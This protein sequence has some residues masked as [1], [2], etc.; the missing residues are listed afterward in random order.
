ELSAASVPFGQHVLHRD[1]ETRS[2]AILRTVGAQ[3]YAADCSTEVL[4]ICY[5]ADSDAIKLWR[6]G[7][8]VP[9]E[10]VVAAQSQN[11]IATA[12]NDAFETAIEKSIMS[13]RYGWPAIPIERHR[14]TQ[15]ACLALGLP[16]KLSAVADALE[17]SHRKD[18]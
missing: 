16:A 14:C 11:W 2:R 4:C 1:I 5:A 13:V 3:R 6:P 12:F 17:L 9:Q 7:D 15:A 10:F 8:P 18:A